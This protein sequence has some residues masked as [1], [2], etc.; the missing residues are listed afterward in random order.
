GKLSAALVS[1][2][3][4]PHLVTEMLKLSA[5]IDILDVPYKGGAPAMLDVIGGQVDMLFSV[6][7][8][9]LPNIQAGELRPLVIASKAR[10]SLVP[11]MPTTV[12]EGYGDVIGSAW[13][14]VV[15]PAG[16]PKAIIDK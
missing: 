10:S 5:G 12:E 8:L 13:N 15:A 4:V 7:P 2:G 9:V 3:S 14:G 16:T 6:L 11:D 1:A